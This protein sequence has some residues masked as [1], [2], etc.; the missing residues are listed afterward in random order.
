MDTRVLFIGANSSFIINAVGD[1]LKQAG[2]DCAFCKLDISEISKLSE[3]PRSILVYVDEKAAAQKEVFVYIRDLCMEED[4]KIFLIGYSDEINAIK[5]LIPENNLG[6]FFERPINVKKI[7]D[8]LRQEIIIADQEA[9]KKHILVVDDSGTMLR[10]IKGWL[11]DKYKVSMVNSATSAI[12]FLATNQPDLI[13]LD[14]E[15]PVCSGPQM[16]EMIRAEIK[17]ESIPVIFLTAKGD[18]ESVEKVLSLRPQGYL[19]KTMPA[20]KIIEAIDNFFIA[21]K[22]KGL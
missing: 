13:L 8:T 22:A 12:S 3:F 10:T 6:G 5:G 18:K 19:L 2:F 4:R 15:M 16:L 9:D 14:Y 7:A 17:T 21:Q 20:E 11:Q 1:G